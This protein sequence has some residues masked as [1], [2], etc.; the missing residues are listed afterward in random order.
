MHADV[1][2]MMLRKARNLFFSLLALVLILLASLSALVETETGSRWVVTRI[3]NFVNITLGDMSG[4]LRSGL[5]IDFVD[6]AQGEHHYRAEQVSFRWRPAALLYSAVSIQSLRAKKVLIQVPPASEKKSTAQ[7]FSQ[8]PSLALPVRIRLDQLTVTNIDY[9]Q[10]ATHLH[11]KKL[12]GSLGLGTFHLRYDNLALQHAD[13]AL[14][15]SGTTNLRFPY[16]TE[17]ML[18]W[19]WQAQP[20]DAEGTAPLAY[21]GVT[22][23]K[24][25]LV[26]LQLHN[27]LSLP[28][29]LSADAT[30]QLVDKKQQLQT[31]PPM[32]LLLSW[33]QQTLPAPWWIHAQPLPITNGKLTATGN[34]RQYTAQLDGD[35]HLPDAP[36]LAITAAAN[37]DLE[38]INVSN[39]FI[40]ELHKVIT[41]DPNAVLDPPADSAS[42]AAGS[43]S[44]TGLQLSG[45]VRWLPQLEWQVTAGAKRLNLA[46]VIDDWSSDINLGFTTSGSRIDGVWQAALQDFQ[47]SGELRGV[48]VR[49]EGD[50]FFEKNALR[51]DAFN[52][53]VGANRL[54]VNGAIGEQFNLDWNLNA[55]LLQQLDE[56]L[57]GS[58]ISSGELRGDWKKPRVQMQASAVKFSW[59]NY[60]VDKLDLS[61]IPALADTVSEKIA[62]EKTVSKKTIPEKTAPEKNTTQ[63]ITDPTPQM[64]ADE[65]GLAD[66]VSEIVNEHYVLAFNAKQLH[67]A[68]QRFST[69]KLDGTGSI[70]QHQ[71]AAVIKS[72][73]YG[74]ADFKL[75]GNYDG[76]EWQG[77]LTQLAIK[78][79]RVPRWW[80]TGSKPIR[81][82][83]TSVQLG[84]Q[85]LTTRSNLT[86][87]VENAE[88]L[89]R[90]QL[91]GEWLPNQSP[92]KS[93]YAWLDQHHALPSSGIEKYSLPQLCIDGEW[94]RTTGAKLNV[95]VDSVPLRQFLALFKVEVY[96]AGVMDG[97]LHATS[98][99]FSLANTQVSTNISTRNA[100]LRYQYSGGT[101]EV[102]AWRNFGV[103]ATLDK[104]LLDVVAGMEWV[105][106]GNID[107][108]S[109]LDLA[110]KKINNG[111]LQARFDNLA[112][113]ETLLTYANDVKGDFR[114]DLTAGGSFTKPYVLGDISLRNGTANLPRLGLDLT[115]IELQIN[116]TQAGD[117]NLVSQLQSGDGRLSLVGD[118]H[119]FGTPDWNLQGFINGADF[120]VISLP[121]LKATLSPDLK[122]TANREA[123]HISGEAVIPWARANIKRLPE[124]AVQVSNDAVIVNENFSTD[125]EAP[126]IEFF[127]NLK[128]SLGDD[129]QFKGFGLNSKLSGKLSLLKESG[130]QFFT[131]GYVS[132]ADGSYKAYG[133]TL[134]ID[135]GRLVFQGPYENPGLDIRASR[136]IKDD[137]ETKVGLEIGG[138]L[139]RPIAHVFSVPTRSESQAMMMLLT[140][141]PANDVTRADASVLL[142]AMSGLG[143]DSDGSIASQITQLF[144][145]DEL[146]VKSDEG[147]DQ[148]QLF[149]GKYLTPKLLVRYVV[150]IF[151]RAFSLG[152]EYQLTKHL[153]LEAESG[154]TQSV[155]VVYKIER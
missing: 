38:K 103:R 7:P 70:N 37:G 107:A 138:T 26:D 82:N 129:V 57:N 116:S 91:I 61:L 152:M 114:A 130:R 144:R 69:L 101:T 31:T 150:G 25:D 48:N 118:L 52:V 100:E 105:G 45:D 148:S 2:H 40:R 86:A 96:F 51:S 92:V 137:D 66:I 140:G 11:W 1:L 12:S 90:E 94:A 44:E 104:A 154:E 88:L 46:S 125:G 106:Y 119:Q 21:M 59:G 134:T 115:N 151:D 43:D 16:D 54:Q 80:L 71:L 28:V 155:D 13:Y 9:V 133:Q 17:A 139:Q 65:N 79:K 74:H 55:P 108:N 81:V 136:V 84:T 72:T 142:G 3:A 120:K 73:A 15:L 10:G 22:E 153:R 50:V 83:K 18:Q 4:N 123:M 32:T 141:K 146:E 63:K 98:Q 53:I 47:L 87:V 121:Q 102:Y 27:Q 95:L 75:V 39:L 34:W 143:V 19:Q 128:L 36:A 6:Y 62:P 60:A 29:V 117:I 76:S 20:Q 99:D 127:T 23:L 33:Q 68:Q 93:P 132:V 77:K 112:P 131:S 49:G 126:P 145:L 135:R 8:W 111:K 110:Q 85:C 113:L 58:V 56:S 30:V 109:Q 5:D 67:V 78:A 24:G 35:I 89:E 147:I 124:S 97:S 42:V 14:H 64:P 149:I 41:S 122:L